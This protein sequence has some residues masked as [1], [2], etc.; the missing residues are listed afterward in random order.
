[1]TE[2]LSQ[3]TLTLLPDTVRQ[4]AYDRAETKVS[5]VHMGPGIFHRAHQA[6]Y[7]DDVLAK[8]KD[9]AIC[10][11]SLNST[12]PGD[13][14]R[15]QT[16]LYTLAVLGDETIC[17]IIGSITD[18]LA[19]RRQQAR[20]LARLSHPDT[21][22]VSLTITEKGY[23]LTADGNLDMDNPD[24]RHDLSEPATPLTAIGYLV[25]SLK[26]RREAGIPPYTVLSCDNLTA[27]GRQ[28]SRVVRQYAACLSADLADWIEDE[29][30]FPCTMVD[31]ITPY[32]DD[33]LKTRVSKIIR[34]TDGWPVQR[35]AFA[36][37]V[38]EDTFSM[39]RPDWE[40]SGIT[41]TANV[42]LYEKAK[43]RLLNGAHSALAYLGIL[44]GFDTVH[45][46]VTEKSLGTFIRDL[47]I[48]EIQPTLENTPDFDLGEYINL[49]LK[50]FR[51]P[52]MTHYLSQIAADGSQKIPVRLADVINDNLEAGRPI[53]NLCL[54]VAAWLH[55]IRKQVQDNMPLTD[56]LAGTLRNIG[57]RCA[58]TGGD[59]VAEILSLESVFPVKVR[60][61]GKFRE[62]LAAAYDTLRNTEQSGIPALLAGR[63]ISI[64]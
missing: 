17:R 2:I 14:L 46:A 35:E 19:A 24:I 21:R 47:M 15:R 49:V 31:S 29:V 63:K 11:I 27:N 32:T 22:I 3:K 7:I 60:T 26:Q 54:A 36:Q 61:S 37:W 38:I 30:C 59:P 8:E 39:G 33:E 43:L 53:E 18:I 57:N 20:T 23:C 48:G 52:A 28:L 13:I 41:M 9:W 6:V 42:D 25:A 16:Y 45:D 10:G 40:F 12:K 51:N 44:A 5:I 1:M 64:T 58:G 56:P 4:P 50:R 34:L 55:F 62:R